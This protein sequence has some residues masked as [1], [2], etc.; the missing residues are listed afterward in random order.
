MCNKQLQLLDM[1]IYKNKIC[2]ISGV[3]FG[4]SNIHQVAAN[5]IYYP[6][7]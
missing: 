4:P 1:Y 7:K 6:A 3:I 5:M 2:C